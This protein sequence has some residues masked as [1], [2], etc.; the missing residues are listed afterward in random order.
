MALPKPAQRARYT[1]FYN[2]PTRSGF[3]RQFFWL[4][5]LLLQEYLLQFLFEF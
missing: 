4:P 2:V 1:L 3:F 5:P